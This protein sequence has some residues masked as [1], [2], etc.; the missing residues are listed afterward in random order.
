MSGS[1]A[2]SVYDTSSQVSLQDL[3]LFR[4]EVLANATDNF[5]EANMLGK[6]GFGPVYKV[7]F[8]VVFVLVE[9]NLCKFLH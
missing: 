1:V 3:P 2:S 7:I 4:F 6:G 8:S 9:I 5:S